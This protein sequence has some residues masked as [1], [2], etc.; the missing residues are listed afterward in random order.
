[1][2]QDDARQILLQGHNV[3]LTG[4]AGSGKSY[5]LESFAR[6]KR[7][8]G[9]QV[10]VTAST[11]IA[12]AHIN[13]T[14]IHNWSG[15]GVRHQQQLENEAALNGIADG[16]L[17]RYRHAI[18]NSNILVIDE[19]S[20]LHAYQL[21]AVDFVVKR[22][23]QNDT[24]FGGLQVILS[25]DFFQLPPI[26]GEGDGHVQFITASQAFING[27][28]RVCYLEELMRHDI[29]DDLVG[30][31]NAIRSNRV[32]PEHRQILNNRVGVELQAGTIAKICTLNDQADQINNARLGA[33]PGEV[34]Q[35]QQQEGGDP[36]ILND[37]RAI[38][39]NKVVPLLRLKADS[40]VMFVKND[41]Q[42]RFFNG[43][44]GRVVS[45]S[46]DGW[47]NVQ[48]NDRVQD[49]QP[50]PGALLHGI[51]PTDFFIAD[52]N[53]QQL[54]TI[55]Q[56]PL[57]LAWAITVN[58]SQG[59]TLDAAEVNLN[60]VH[61]NSVGIGYVALSRVRSIQNLSLAL[62]PNHARPD[63][64]PQALV[65]SPAALAM[66]ERLQQLSR[67]TQALLREEPSQ[68]DG[69]LQPVNHNQF[70]TTQ[71]I[72]YFLDELIKN[73]QQRIVLVTPYIKLN[74]RLQ[75]LLQEKKRAGVEIIFICR[76]DNLQEELAAYAT[77][78]R[79]KL[80]LHAKCYFSERE[81]I[82]TSL[83]LYTFSQINNEEMGVYMKNDG[84][85]ALYAGVVKEV[86]RLMFH[87]KP[88]V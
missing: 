10:S 44:L 34:H 61:P 48:L 4:E 67:E 64:H 29:N 66:E 62:H 30:V 7:E 71:G 51:W 88:L 5:L 84:D 43:S 40:V 19:I 83:N 23:R 38:C 60:W 16:M 8:Q 87:S 77:S 79:I 39:S 17:E 78:V 2:R 54:A 37:L 57:R 1:M 63:I 47:P 12:A 35:Y 76:G 41:P 73:A 18:I 6:L 33:L 45:F 70:I 26:P 27:E 75:E 25:G 53:G 80:N 21:T 50:V 81:A 15:I 31:L 72:N 9:C 20:M 52:E 55:R 74:P 59:M 86:E 46:N 68:N 24:P 58:K 13:G 56:V 85:N 69:V 22:V 82:V 3:L 14:T 42:G 65:I 11:G 28:F 36:L 32:T 49:G